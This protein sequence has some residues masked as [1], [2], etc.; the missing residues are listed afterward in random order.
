[1]HDGMVDVPDTVGFGVTID[2]G[3]LERFRTEAIEILPQG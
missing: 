3:K 1:M 2:P